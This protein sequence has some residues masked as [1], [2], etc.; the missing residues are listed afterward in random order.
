M[1]YCL[2]VTLKEGIVFASDSRTNA[3]FDKISTYSKMHTFGKDGDRQIVIMSAGN[4]AT[5]QAVIARIKH[6]IEEDKSTHLFN[7]SKLINAADYLGDIS[8]QNQT[9]H[10][11]MA[12]SDPD[13]KPEATFIIGGQ[14][15]TRNH[16]AY[17][18]YPEGNHITTSPDTPYLQIG[19]SKYGKPILDRI[20]KKDSTLDEAAKCAMVSMDSTMRSNLTV[21]PPIE[22]ITYQSNTLKLQHHLKFDQNHPYL[23]VLS[24]RWDQQLIKAFDKLPDIN[25]GTAEPE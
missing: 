7:V 1:T 2:V 20:L 11:N 4:L 18:V 13:F 22:M 23:R 15:G 3:G 14:I 19:E 5:T 10:S 6:D 12:A 16:H 9:K 25:W 8:L 24:K 21:G 17:M